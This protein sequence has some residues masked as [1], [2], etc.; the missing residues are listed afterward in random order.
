MC[1]C[2]VIKSFTILFFIRATRMSVHQNVS[3]MHLCKCLFVLHQ[4]CLEEPVD[5]FVLRITTRHIRHM[6]SKLSSRLMFGQAVRTLWN[7]ELGFSG[8][9]TRESRSSGKRRSRSALSVEDT[10]FY[11]YAIESNRVGSA[12]GLHIM[13]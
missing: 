9:A 3:I 12:T 4:I 8:R 13:K 5:R 6:R 10:N 1:V 7:G 11:G 2:L